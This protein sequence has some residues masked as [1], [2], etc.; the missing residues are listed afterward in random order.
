MALKR[1]TPLRSH[2][3]LSP[4]SAK[5]M[6]QLRAA[7]LPTNSTFLPRQRESR[8]KQPRRRDTGPLR[9]TVEL[10]YLRSGRICEWPGCVQ[11]ATEKH[12]RLNRK[13]GG[14]HGE[15]RER[16]NGVAWLLH[17]CQT[18]HAYVTSPTGDQRQRALDMGW[19]LLEYQDALQVPALTRHDDEP[20]WLDAAGAWHLFEVGVA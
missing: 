14:R 11:P 13:Y 12:H 15:A 1:N 4:M 6:E 2:T 19:L 10:L 18:H 7:G 5:R 3:A 8:V 20:V 16:V 17:A 9:S